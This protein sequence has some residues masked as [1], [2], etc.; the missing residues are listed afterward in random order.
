MENTVH[1]LT[2]TVES[3][4]CAFPLAAVERVV[5]AVEV[6]PLPEVST[7]ILGVIDVQGE[8]V[9]VI[10]ARQRFG[11]AHREVRPADQFIIVRTSRGVRA[12]VV[13]AVHEVIRC[14]HG[15]IAAAQDVMPGAGCVEGMLRS[16][17]GIAIVCDPERLLTAEG[18]V[19]LDGSLPS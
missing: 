4:R 13:D 17:E 14:S 9:P 10:S 3:Q 1:L 7:G 12:L 5:R 11:L 15:D 16:G 19:A 18:A 2:C 6:T 8:I